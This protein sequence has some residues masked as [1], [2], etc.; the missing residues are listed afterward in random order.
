LISF[1]IAAAVNSH[2]VFVLVVYA[3][4]T[5]AYSLGLKRVPVLDVFMLAFLF[6][7]RLIYGV[8]LAEVAASPW[9]L[10]FSMFLFTS[11][12]AAK[13]FTE[14][15]RTAVKGE[16]SVNGRGYLVA[17][18]PLVLG[19]GL[20][21]G[22]ASIL[23]MVLY[24][25]FDAFSRDFYGNPHWLWFFPVILFLWISMTTLSPSPSRTVRA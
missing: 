9:L 11:L 2:A 21:T 8:Y 12:S 24:L 15:Q 18:A 4:S 20:A 5:A 13:R 19:L 10:V 14:I 22:T 16:T 23:I 6:T 3:A 1:A 25:I 7:L 17:D